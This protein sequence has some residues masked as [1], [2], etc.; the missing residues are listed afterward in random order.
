LRLV[1]VY[2]DAWAKELVG[3]IDAAG[4]TPVYL[5]AVTAIGGK[6][7]VN[8]SDHFGIDRRL[9]AAIVQSLL[10]KPGATLVEHGVF[11]SRFAC[12]NW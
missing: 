7:P 6:S 11:P 2:D 1:P 5:D 10:A 3:M 4:N 8:G 9:P 12:P